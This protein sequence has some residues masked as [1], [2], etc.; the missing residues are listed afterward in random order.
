VVVAVIGSL[1][2]EK[3]LVMKQSKW[4][5]IKGCHYCI[6]DEI[7]DKKVK[8]KSDYNEFDDQAFLNGY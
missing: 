4:L 3:F 8:P 6:E 7:E 2:K 1:K 5:K